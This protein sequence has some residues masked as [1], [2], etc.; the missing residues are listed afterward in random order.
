M[1]DVV[2]YIRGG[3]M[4]SGEI[5]GRPDRH[6]GTRLHV[7]ACVERPVGTNTV[8]RIAGVRSGS[9]GMAVVA[10]AEVWKCR[11]GRPTQDRRRLRPRRGEK[12]G[13][14]ALSGGLSGPTTIDATVMGGGGP[15]CHGCLAGPGLGD[16]VEPLVAC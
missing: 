2:E 13:V 10:C 4:V 1:K 8:G 7:L 3:K 11:A 5:S 15:T 6:P 16:V 14:T 9:G 12:D